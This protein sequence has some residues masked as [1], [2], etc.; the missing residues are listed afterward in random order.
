M[1]GDTQGEAAKRSISE[2]FASA[3][4]PLVK[5]Y[6]GPERK[7]FTFPEAL[8]CDRFKFFRA[9]FEGGFRESTEKSID[10]PEDDPVAFSFVIDRALQDT[11]D[12]LTKVDAKD[13]QLVLCK[14][15]LLADKLGRSDIA[16][17]AEREWRRFLRTRDCPADRIMCPQAVKLL[18]NNTSEK[19]TLFRDNMVHIATNTYFDRGCMSSNVL[20]KWLKSVSSHSEFHFEVMSSIKQKIVETIG[21][22]GFCHT[23]ECVL[24]H[25]S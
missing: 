20:E 7:Q 1:S 2:Y 17:D 18:Y 3:S 10:L 13:V 4:L 8:L 22:I 23:S 14:A 19:T 11:L 25:T 9:A 21:D 15:Y 5:V 12:I 24:H 16:D 6:V